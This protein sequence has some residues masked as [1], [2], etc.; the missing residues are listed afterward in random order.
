MKATDGVRE[1]M[2]VR[3]VRFV[4]LRKRLGLES[5]TMSNRL[6]QENISIGKLNEMLRVLDYKVVI[7]P[8]DTRLR[9]G[10]YEV[11]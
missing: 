2:K 4:D 9:E 8:N 1:V 10:E 6:S 5:N 3:G 7:M 11:E